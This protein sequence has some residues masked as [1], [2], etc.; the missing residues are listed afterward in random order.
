[1][2]RQM[3]TSMVVLYEEEESAKSLSKS[4]E[5]F[6]KLHRLTAAQ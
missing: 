6:R 4:E 5:S 3:R 2:R 1:M